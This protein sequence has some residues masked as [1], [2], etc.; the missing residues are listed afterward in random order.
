MNIMENDNILPAAIDTKIKKS[1]SNR[2]LDV[3]LWAVTIVVFCTFA[4]K[5]WVLFTDVFVDLTMGT[6]AWLV[7]L[8][9]IFEAGL[10][11]LLI[12]ERQVASKWIV[13]VAGFAVFSLFSLGW[14][15]IGKQ[16]CGCLGV[17]EVSP[18]LMLC[19]DA[20]VLLSLLWFRPN[21]A[22]V[23]ESG[24]KFSQLTLKPES[25]GQ[26][27][28][29]TCCTGMFVAFQAGLLSKIAPSLLPSKVVSIDNVD[30]GEVEA[31]V[32][33]CQILLKNRSQS[34]IKIIGDQKS[35]TCIITD[36]GRKKPSRRKGPMLRLILQ[37]RHKYF[38]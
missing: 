16:S 8:S 38:S 11:W 2:S 10:L 34:D 30:I 35:C 21:W 33:T 6:P 12:N 13:A 17:I 36:A 20:T 9:V 31:G 1:S 14:V 23:S 29:I 15:L 5:L 26:L 27:A 25:I 22:S 3:L 4:S 18:F 32:F 37:N 24:R 28:A 19:F 7:W